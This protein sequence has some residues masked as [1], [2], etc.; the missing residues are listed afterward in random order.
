M[1][2]DP[3]LEDVFPKANL[4]INERFHLGNLHLMKDW[5]YTRACE[6]QRGCLQGHKEIETVSHNTDMTAK[7]KSTMS[8][9]GENTNFR[10]QYLQRVH[11]FKQRPTSFLKYTYSLKGNV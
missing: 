2:Q 7:K 3:G 5:E 11:V 1:P 6:I 8:Q 10:H 9:F 4:E